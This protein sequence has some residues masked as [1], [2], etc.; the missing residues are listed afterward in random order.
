ML[1]HGHRKKKTDVAEH[2][3]VFGHVGLLVNGSP[4]RAGYPSSSHPTNQTIVHIAWAKHIILRL[5][6]G[7]NAGSS[8]PTPKLRA[9]QGKTTVS[10]AA[11]PAGAA[12]K[13]KA[14]SHLVHTGEAGQE[15]AA[16][17][18]ELRQ[19]NS[20]GNFNIHPLDR[21]P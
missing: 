5:D 8:I 6:V 7:R 10:A 14:S 15:V 19:R 21:G 16:R 3:Q 9:P 17:C 20:A 11:L 12:K 2:P 13:G 4:D 1:D 18:L